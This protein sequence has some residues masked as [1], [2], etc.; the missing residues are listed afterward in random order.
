MQ[1]KTQV[2]GTSRAE[3]LYLLGLY[4]VYLQREGMN[5]KSETIHGDEIEICSN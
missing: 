4:N 3:F 2:A 1:Q 5:L